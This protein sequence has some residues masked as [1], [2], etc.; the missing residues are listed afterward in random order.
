MK[1]RLF[2]Y[3]G[4]GIE[5]HHTRDEDPEAVDVVLHAH[6]NYE[7]YHFLSGAGSYAIEG[8]EYTLVPGCLLVMRDG[9]AHTVHLRNG[10]PYERICVNFAPETM[11]LLGEEIRALYRNRPLG[12]GNFFKPDEDSAAFIAACMERLCRD[13]GCEDYEERARTVLGMLLLELYK[14]KERTLGEGEGDGAPPRRS[15]ETVQ[16]IIAY[17]NENLTTIRNSDELEREFFFSKS[18]INRIFKQSTGTS[19]WEYIVLKRLHLAR[20]LLREGKQAS[21]VAAE[22]GFCDY[23]SFYRQYRRR[24]G[25]AP[26][27]A[28]TKNDAPPP[29]ENA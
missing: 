23:S 1:E 13:E 6:R 20:S 24:F 12:K 27:S 5:V 17:V 16:K 21:I 28:R 29:R 10:A 8:N 11:P 15:A 9:E 25:A 2:N 26:R 14:L 4:K 19:V 3:K 22:C 18:Y 7:L